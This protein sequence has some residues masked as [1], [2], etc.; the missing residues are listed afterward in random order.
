[1]QDMAADGATQTLVDRRRPGRLAEVSPHL[2]PLL[3]AEERGSLPP[4]PEETYEND[5]LLG[6]GQGLALGIVLGG[7]LWAGII[8]T[9][10][11]VFG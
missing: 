7:A 3:R 11:L 10:W 2:L 6:A 1:M 8:R 5:R 9:L 4:L